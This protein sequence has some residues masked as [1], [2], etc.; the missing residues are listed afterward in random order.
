[1]AGRDICGAGA[2]QNCVRDGRSP[3]AEAMAAG[4][5]GL[6]N[7]PIQ[8]GGGQQREAIEPR[9]CLRQP[10]EVGVVARIDGGKVIAVRKLGIRGRW[11]AQ[12][13]P[14]AQLSSL[15]RWARRDTDYLGL[16]N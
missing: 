12:N 13:F 14:W 10:R 6:G 3:D 8:F 5:E 4:V 9:T 2:I 11:T 15:I 16:I 1:M 7:Q